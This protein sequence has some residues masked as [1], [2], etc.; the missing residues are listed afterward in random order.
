MKGMS[1]AALLLLASA[2][3]FASAGNVL[4]KEQFGGE[5]FTKPASYGYET[6][7]TIDICKI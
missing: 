7:F 3:A 1:L 4:Y 2:L 5:Y 6:I